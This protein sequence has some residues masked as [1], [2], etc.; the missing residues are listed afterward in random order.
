MA[1]LPH[2]LIATALAAASALTA[3]ACAPEPAARSAQRTTITFWTMP[4]W[5]GRPDNLKHL[6][7]DF[8]ASQNKVEVRLTVLDW[9]TG[10]ETIKKAVQNGRGPD[11]W[12]ANNGLELDLLTGARLAPLDTLGYT[13]E[14][15]GRFRPLVKVNEYRGRLYGAPL[16]FDVNVLLYRKDILQKYGF[17]QPP[18]TWEELKSTAAA[19]TTRSAATGKKVSGWQFKGMDD[20]LN[21][22]NPTW[23]SFLCQAGGSLTS[24]D[25]KT[26]TQSTEAGRTAMTYMKSFYTDKISPAGTSALGG[27]IEGDVAMF[28]FYQSVISDIAAGNE[29]TNGKW[30]VA[31]MPVGPRSGCSAVGGHSLVARAGLP[32]PGA[33]GA[34]MRWLSSPATS[35]QFMEFHGI[36]PYDTAKVP[37]ETR[38]VVESFYNTD[39][40]WA[41]IMTQFDR[42]TADLLLQ[43][44][45]GFA[46][47]WEAQKTDVV[48]GVDGR[49]PVDQALRSI[50]DKVGRELNG[51]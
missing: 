43:D 13:A 36:F 37:R 29:K 11:V 48:A 12:L 14:D 38:V 18:R 49:T 3:G 15:L 45:Y 24:P 44:R 17:D 31:P 40:S 25:F 51:G 23:E 7:E 32:D 28:S 16:Y 4:F 33:A 27:F 26:S 20:H 41:A 2:R 39:P 42:S 21:A 35:S 1:P 47:R 9:Q 34:F 46:S 8:N 19:V 10:R 50:D 30:A 22:I 5:I 6:V